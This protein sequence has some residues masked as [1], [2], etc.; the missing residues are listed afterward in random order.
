MF[1]GV[2]L[3]IKTNNTEHHTSVISSER[4]IVRR[5]Q[6]FTVTLNLKEAFNP[7]V[8]PLT[9]VAVTGQWLIQ[10]LI[11]KTFNIRISV[12]KLVKSTLVNHYFHL[13]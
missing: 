6:P 11:L 7:D 10:L 5:G 2:E 9:V 13:I 4:L 8:Y 3:N 1:K 12:G